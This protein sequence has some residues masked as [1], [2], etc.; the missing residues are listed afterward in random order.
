MFTFVSATD[1][2]EMEEIS[3]KTKAALSA[4]IST[5]FGKPVHI[6]SIKRLRTTSP[7]VDPWARQGRIAVQS[8]H[9]L[10]RGS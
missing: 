2:R 5:F 7:G 3:S 9:N 6:R 4:K 8:S 10:E 1:Q